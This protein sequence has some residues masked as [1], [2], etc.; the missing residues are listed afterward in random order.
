MSNEVKM[1]STVCPHCGARL[2]VS[3]GL[4]S[5]FCQFCGTQY[6]VA[7]AVTNSNVYNTTNNITN[8]TTINQ[9]NSVRVGRK[10]MV[11]AI[12]DY[13]EN[14]KR[15]EQEEE[16]RRAE[17]QRIETEKMNAFVHKH[18]KILISLFMGLMLSQFIFIAVEAESIMTFFVSML[19]L[20]ALFYTFL[21]AAAK[22][23]NAYRKAEN[24]AQLA[25]ED[26][27]RT[28]DFIKRYWKVILT[29]SCVIVLMILI[30]GLANP[31]DKPKLL[32]D[33]RIEKVLCPISSDEWHSAK[34]SD[35]VIKFN[36]AGFTN[37]Q[38]TALNDLLSADMDMEN[39]VE[40]VS[41]GGKEDFSKE[42]AYMS[43]T[44]IHIAYHS[45][46]KAVLPL[47]SDDIHSDDYNS[48]VKR[49]K[50]AGFTN[51]QTE[52]IDDLITGWL[53]SDGETEKV[54]IDGSSEFVTGESY[55][56]DVEIIISYH[57]FS[58]ADTYTE[59]ESETSAIEYSE[60]ETKAETEAAIEI[61]NSEN[62]K[63]L[64]DVLS[65]KNTSDPI[66]SDFVEKYRGQ[67][68]EFD[69][70]TAG[71]SH[72]NDFKT[73]Y[74]YLIYSGDYGNSSISGP[75]FQFSDVSYNDLK[76]TGENIPDSF[77]IGLDIHIVAE[78]VK[79]DENSEL[80][81]IKPVSVSIR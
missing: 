59:E 45:A 70:Y 60:T 30:S 21:W 20:T 81:I 73:R 40:S 72:H 3:E 36:S 41:V 28:V 50:D 66:I 43:D 29:I 63:E 79:F 12:L 48:I 33:T 6:L 62:C 14:R 44:E 11:E 61:L 54:T 10:G 75:Y 32:A 38:V 76:L 68:I 7:N 5:A 9:T 69:G 15:Q 19:F 25:K 8:S 57:T 65:T 64:A 49:F 35:L 17:E 1:V 53:V 27:Q 37:V 22:K 71:V 4:E 31:T 46:K 26:F 13:A 51:V 78:I 52:K 2:E 74:D 42:D 56:A 24:K 47:S 16:R 18:W 80:F 58:E 39:I 55:I 67:L 34:C 77:G 23:V